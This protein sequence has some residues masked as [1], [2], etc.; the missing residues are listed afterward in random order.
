MFYA[1][2]TMRCGMIDFLW[3]HMSVDLAPDDG[4]AFRDAVIMKLVPKD[5]AFADAVQYVSGAAGPDAA[6]KDQQ[7]QAALLDTCPFP[8]RVHA[9]LWGMPVTP[10]QMVFISLATDVGRMVKWLGFSLADT[11]GD[12]AVFVDRVADAEERGPALKAVRE[13][14]QAF[15]DTLKRHASHGAAALRDLYRTLVKANA[16][17]TPAGPTAPAKRTSLVHRA[18]V[19]PLKALMLCIALGAQV[20]VG[21][22]A[23]EHITQL[24][25]HLMGTVMEHVAAAGKRLLR[26]PADAVRA[27]HSIARNS[28]RRVASA[29]A[30]GVGAVGSYFASWF[31]GKGG[32][33]LV[34][35]QGPFSR[36]WSG[37]K[38][39]VSERVLGPPRHAHNT[40]VDTAPTT[41]TE[42][43]VHKAPMSYGE[44]LVDVTKL[45]CLQGLQQRPGFVTDSAS[46][47]V[48]SPGDATEAALEAKGAA[49]KV[50]ARQE[51]DAALD[52]SNGSE[53]PT[54]GVDESPTLAGGGRRHYNGTTYSRTHVG[55]GHRPRWRHQVGYAF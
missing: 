37:V 27:L 9:R 14:V 32:R 18:I 21:P 1:Y 2:G 6:S 47:V 53:S 31:R 28:A 20:T 46:G 8:D 29:V 24:V 34:H 5:M 16:E 11:L 25:R 42:H 15:A 52:N 22:T 39:Y 43:P 17:E 33:Y 45:K 51:T 3:Q 40:V 35:Y 23:V 10:H 12:V 13:K 55:H 4:T 54:P 19:A 36:L 48:H 50:E 38:K 30:A 26:L 7:F 44:A 49:A 41:S